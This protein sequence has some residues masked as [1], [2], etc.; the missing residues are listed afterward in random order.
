MRDSIKTELQ[1]ALNGRFGKK[2]VVRVYFPQYV[3]Q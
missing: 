3:V 1:D 2:T